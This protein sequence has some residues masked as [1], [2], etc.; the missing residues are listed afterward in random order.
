MK[1]G[2]NTIYLLI[3]LKHDESQLIASTI[4][5]MGLMFTVTWPS[6]S[7]AL[8]AILFIKVIYQAPTYWYNF[9]FYSSNINLMEEHVTDAYGILEEIKANIDKVPISFSTYS[10]LND[11]VI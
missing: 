9:V 1:S 8:V 11:K 5:H 10:S 7:S 3:G 2:V 6:N 4:F